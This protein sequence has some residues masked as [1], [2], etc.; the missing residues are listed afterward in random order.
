MPIKGAKATVKVAKAPPGVAK[1][2][3]VK[4]GKAAGVEQNIQ[5]ASPQVREAYNSVKDWLGERCK[6]IRNNDEVMVLMSEDGLRKFRVD[7]DYTTID[8]S[9]FFPMHTHLQEL[10]N[11][12][13]KDAVKGFHKIY[14]KGK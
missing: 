5:N 14:P 3:G 4:V 9:K 11:G 13:W 6:M 10:K 1:N 7:L 12:K 2:V 8:G